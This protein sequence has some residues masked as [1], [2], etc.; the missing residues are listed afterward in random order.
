MKKKL[1]VSAND[2]GLTSSVNEGIFWTLEREN[3]IIR[4]VFVLPNAPKI[5]DLKK[6]NEFQIDYNLTIN[7]TS[8]K[9]MSRE[10]SSLVDSNG[11]FLNPKSIH[12]DLSFSK[13]FKSEDIKKEILAQIN[14]FVENFGETPAC[15]NFRKSLHADSKILDVAL[16]II[17]ELKIGISLPLWEADSDKFFINYLKKK[18]LLASEYKIICPKDFTGDIDAYNFVKEEEI[19][20]AISKLKELKGTSQLSFLPGFVNKELFEV[21][22][23]TYQRLFPMRA[24]K[25][26][27]LNKRILK[28][29]EPVSFR[30]LRTS[31]LS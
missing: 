23:L 12:K 29:F 7:L 17:E 27:L 6:L 14:W 3:N 5:N 30:Q 21:S 18:S 26:G 28:S 1:I 25:N 10:V 15:I 22:D 31:E 24:F 2:F 9:P 20:D 19:E 13:E 4:E 11:N 8:F 16:E